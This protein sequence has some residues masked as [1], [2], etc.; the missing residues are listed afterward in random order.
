MAELGRRKCTNVM[1]EA[2]SELLGSLLD[3]S[4]VDEVHVFIAP[5][6]VGGV[7]A[8]PAIAGIGASSIPEF[9]NVINVRQRLISDDVLI[10]GDV[11]R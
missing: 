6:L 7:N 3:A 4:L 2:G 9:P 1:T 11:L 5:R 10:E 8:R